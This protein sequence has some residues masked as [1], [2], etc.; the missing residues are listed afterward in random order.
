MAH[1]ME[2][3]DDSKT[4][5]GYVLCDFIYMTFWKVRTPTMKNRSMVSRGK[6]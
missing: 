3:N 5:K 6:V 2:R 4:T 1:Y